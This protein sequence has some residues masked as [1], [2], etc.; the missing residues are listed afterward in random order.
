MAQ[1]RKPSLP[2]VLDLPLLVALA[3]T[4]GFY[5]LLM[6]ESLKDSMV[7]HY[8]TE[9]AAEYVIVTFF[10]WGL[11]DVVFR[12][13]GFPAEMWA[14]RQPWLPARGPREPVAHAAT[15]LAQLQKKPRWL[16]QSRMGQR[17]YAALGYLKEQ[18]SASGF[19]DH[20]RYLAELDEEKTH[21]NYALVRFICWVTPMLGFLGTVVH[22]GT[23]LGGQEAKEIGDKL[24]TV[25]AEMGTA[26]NTTTVALIAATSMMFC[27]FLCERTERGIVHTIDRRLD[28]ELLHRFEVVDAC[29]APFLTALEA[30]T[31][32]NL[33]AMDATLERQLQIW[34]GAFHALAQQSEQRNETQASSWRQALESLERRFE[35]HQ[36]QRD[37]QLARVLETIQSERALQRAEVRTSVEQLAA[38]QSDFARLV[39]G[40]IAVTESKGEVVKLQAALA[41][42]L[43]LL[44]ETGQIDEALHGL[45]AAIHLLTARSHSAPLKEHRAA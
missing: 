43:R 33:N 34:S 32:A 17:L 37:S 20:L 35:A 24:P 26:F 16:L 45:T 11:T 15:L 2:K 29:I 42:N 1:V 4:V 36:A 19:A 30:A 44:R 41:E 3:L 23:A 27:L 21:G 40:L 10:I 5:L 12:A 18:G 31:N 25:V 7:A 14:L 13:L 9:H 8:T 39:E 38:L 22:F 28:R 6:H